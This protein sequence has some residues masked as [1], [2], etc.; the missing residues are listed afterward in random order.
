MSQG[1][2]CR[3]STGRASLGKGKWFALEMPAQVIKGRWLHLQEF[4]VEGI[5]I[6]VASRSGNIF[7]VFLRK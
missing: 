7:A 6:C 5:D 4:D 3:D 2:N 1:S